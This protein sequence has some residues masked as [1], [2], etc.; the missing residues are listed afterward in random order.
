MPFLY[1]I[2]YHFAR[3]ASCLIRLWA[4]WQIKGS[5]NV[6]RKGPVLVVANHMT[7]VDVPLLA[8]SL[9][10]KAT[11]MGKEELFRTRLSAWLFFHALNTF[12]VYRNRADLTAIRRA[13]EVLARGRVL[14]MFPEGTRSRD[15]QLQPALTGPVLLARRGSAPILP[16]G[17]S[18]TEKIKGFASLLRRPR[19]TVNIGPPF[20]LPDDGGRL[21]KSK[22]A[23]LTG[24]IM[25]RIADL[26]P[27]EYRGFYG[28]QNGN[29]ESQ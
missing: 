12:P 23:E 15:S 6:P 2:V 17:I 10:R 7:L 21:T 1:H 5:E 29:Q 20:Y 18:G 24:I 26:L 16:V 4:C 8:M 13:K 19:V 14:V 9:G 22:R 25:G 28:K 3:A 27:P 11:F